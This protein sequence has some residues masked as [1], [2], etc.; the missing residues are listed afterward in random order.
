MSRRNSRD[1]GKGLKNFWSSVKS[2]SSGLE[3]IVWD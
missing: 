2:V 3:G 1:G